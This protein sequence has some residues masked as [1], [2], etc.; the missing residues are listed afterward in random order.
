MNDPFYADPEAYDLAYGW[1]SFAE[2]VQLIQR[3]AQLRGRPVARALEVGCGP[4]RVLRDLAALGLTAIGLDREPGLLAWA[5][6]RAGELGLT[7]ETALADM[8]DFAL[9]APVD[10]ALCPLNGVGDL[11]GPDDLARHLAAVAAN[12]TPRGVYVVEM[13]FAPIEKECVGRG[14]PWTMTRGDLRVEADWRL[15]DVDGAAGLAIYEARL[16]IERAGAA[17]QC[18]ISHRVH[19]KWD[20]PLLYAQI[21]A[22][23]L[24][25][26]GL[27]AGDLTPLDPGRRLTYADDNVFVFLQKRA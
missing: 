15:V 23:P 24:V 27:F 12:L 16:A 5:R 2:T 1:D 7:V 11:T 20:Q 14:A 10:I 19:R 21:A 6:R 17:P 4:G 13:S 3:A 9:A 8:R 26:A 22:S 25:L 18:L